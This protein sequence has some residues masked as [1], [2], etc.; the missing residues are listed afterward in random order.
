MNKFT[1][2]TE[3]Q[4]DE[5][6][7]YLAEQEELQKTSLDHLI[8][9]SLTEEDVSLIVEGLEGYWE[10]CKSALKCDLPEDEEKETRD[11]MQKLETL[12]SIFTAEENS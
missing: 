2:Y 4:Q 10:A 9:K 11:T 8:G 12:M 7:T 3:V 1:M 6:T 5:I